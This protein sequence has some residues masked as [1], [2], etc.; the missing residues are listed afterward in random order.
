MTW[1][2]GSFLVTPCALTSCH[3]VNRRWQHVRAVGSN[4]CV[5]GRR[6]CDENH[7]GIFRQ[8]T[9]DQSRARNMQPVRGISTIR[10]AWRWKCWYPLAPRR[11]YGTRR[12]PFSEYMS[13]HLPLKLTTNSRPP[14]RIKWERYFYK[15]VF[16][17]FIEFYIIIMAIQHQEHFS[18]D[19]QRFKSVEI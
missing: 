9:E 4:R 6:P 7:V 12:S 2:F 3:A 13:L 11:R 10:L 1:I 16:R 8:S 14:F 19:V 15:E 17:L 18:G 5:M